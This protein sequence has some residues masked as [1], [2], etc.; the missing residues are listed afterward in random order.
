M[1]C[2]NARLN[3][4]VLCNITIPKVLR[5]LATVALD[6]KKIYDSNTETTTP[7]PTCL[8]PCCCMYP[9]DVTRYLPITLREFNSSH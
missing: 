6:E 2:W 1:P 5:S 3:T 8:L 7:F 4:S 9:L